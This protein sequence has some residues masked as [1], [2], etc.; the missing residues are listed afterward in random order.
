MITDVVNIFYD[1]P[2][3]LES[4]NYPE[5]KLQMNAF[6]LEVNLVISMKATENAYNY[7]LVISLLA[8]YLKEIT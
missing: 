2:L 3:P 6:F 8:C 7:A 1:I 5:S 4:M